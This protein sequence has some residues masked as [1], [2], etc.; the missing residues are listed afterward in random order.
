MFSDKKI[1]RLFLPRGLLF[2]MSGTEPELTMLFIVLAPL[3]MFKELGYMYMVPENNL[4]LMKLLDSLRG[5]NTLPFV[6]IA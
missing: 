6:L 2:L 4:Q 5:I 3:T 1:L